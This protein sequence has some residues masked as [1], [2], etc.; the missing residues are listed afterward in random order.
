MREL[1]LP[2]LVVL[3][4]TRYY[5]FFENFVKR[6]IEDRVEAKKNSLEGF[7]T[8]IVAM[9]LKERIKEGKNDLK[10][11]FSDIWAKIKLELEAEES[12]SRPDRLET[13]AYGTLTKQRVGR[14][15]REVLGSKV[16]REWENNKTRVYHVF[17][18][19]KL[20]KAIRKY[21][22]ADLTDLTD[23]IDFLKDMAKKETMGNAAKT[24]E[25]PVSEAEEKPIH[26]RESVRMVR[27]VRPMTVTTS[28]QEH[29]GYSKPSRTT[30]LGPTGLL[31]Q[32]RRFLKT[33]GGDMGLFAVCDEIHGWPLPPELKADDLPHQA[34]ILKRL[35]RS[36]KY[37][38]KRLDFGITNRVLRI[39][40]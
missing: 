3:K 21:H 23:L 15:L 38:K 37:W 34:F 9:I 2:L 10:I 22:I 35:I 29:E 4:E 31:I 19:S 16:K 28:I 1:Y 25:K 24:E 39:A 6:M 17:K 33:N 32:L 27:A 18:A 40:E 20:L 36:S 7:L 8:K 26:P 11:E 12:P 30:P 14:R 5:S 13:D